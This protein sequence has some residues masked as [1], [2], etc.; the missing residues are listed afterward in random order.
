[1][2]NRYSFYKQYDTINI[3]KNRVF[4]IEMKMVRTFYDN[5]YYSKLRESIRFRDGYWTQGKRKEIS[6]AKEYFKERR[7]RHYQKHLTVDR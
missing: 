4:L 5:K 3:D 6:L 2:W 7:K 1:M